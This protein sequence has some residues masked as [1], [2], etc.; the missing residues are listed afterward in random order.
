MGLGEL[1]EILEGNFARSFHIL[2]FVPG[3]F[4][5]CPVMDQ[6]ASRVYHAYAANS[7]PPDIDLN[8]S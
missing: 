1:V 6:T 8:G 5:Q 3:L 7:V 2:W 4:P